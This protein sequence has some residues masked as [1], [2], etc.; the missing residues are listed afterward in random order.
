VPA[1][2][3]AASLTDPDGNTTSPGPGYASLTRRWTPGDEVLLELPMPV[4]L[5]AAHPRVDAVHRA[6][7]IERGPLV[8]A[9]EQTDLPDGLVVDDLRLLSDDPA[10]FRAEHRPDLLGGCVAVTGRI[11]STNG[12]TGQLTAVPYCLWANRELGP[13]RVW[14]PLP[15]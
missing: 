11:G 1:W 10:D 9:V 13:M 6:R 2:C 8:Y 3:E 7:A 12:S 5:T 15:D 4:R 14:L